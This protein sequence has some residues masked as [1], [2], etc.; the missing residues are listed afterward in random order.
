MLKRVDSG[1]IGD[2]DDSAR[3]D[4]A[5]ETCYKILHDMKECEQKR[6]KVIE[7]RELYRKLYRRKVFVQHRLGVNR[8]IRD[9]V[10]TL[11]QTGDLVAIPKTMTIEKYG[12]VT[13][14]YRILTNTVAKR[15]ASK[16]AKEHADSEKSLDQEA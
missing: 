12:T 8:A 4:V 1:D 3:M 13:Q 7:Y 10:D 9:T 5:L 16:N 11:L 14:H 6:D 2:S 15:R